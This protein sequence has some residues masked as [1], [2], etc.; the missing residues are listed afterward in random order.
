MRKIGTFFFSIPITFLIG[1]FI[2]GFILNGLETALLF[3]GM[4]FQ[5]YWPMSLILLFN[6]CMYHFEGAREK[7][8]TK[9]NALI[10]AATTLSS[11]LL[12]GIINVHLILYSS[13]P[14]LKAAR[15]ILT[16]LFNARP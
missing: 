11:I 9:Q 6:G 1:A 14:A 10:I 5:C 4:S 8:L 3:L 12:M 2:A 13:D 15:L 16:D 7:N